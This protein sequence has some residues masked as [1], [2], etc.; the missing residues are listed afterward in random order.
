MMERDERPRHVVCVRRYPFQWD[1]RGAAGGGGGGRPGGGIKRL[2]PQSALNS[3]SKSSAAA[4]LRARRN[5]AARAAPGYEYV[6]AR[7]LMEGRGKRLLASVQ[8]MRRSRSTTSLKL[9]VSLSEDRRIVRHREEDARDATYK[10]SS[11]KQGRKGSFRILMITGRSNV[12][13]LSIEIFTK[14]PHFF[15]SVMNEDV[16][17]TFDINATNIYIYNDKCFS[18]IINNNN[19]SND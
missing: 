13:T 11:R 4:L 7:T 8:E 6:C 17:Y 9:F 19:D 5:A 3:L 18:I 2:L 16:Q 12:T 10:H 15:F 1:Q 14:I